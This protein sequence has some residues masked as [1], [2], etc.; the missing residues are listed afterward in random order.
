L[1]L[2]RREKRANAE[3]PE[4]LYKVLRIAKKGVANPVLLSPDN[5]NRLKAAIA[6]A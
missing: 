6:I 1:T 3:P 4:H 5:Q 2:R